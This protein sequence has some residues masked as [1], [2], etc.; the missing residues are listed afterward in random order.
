M[1]G[2]LGVIFGW[3]KPELD[4]EAAAFFRACRPWGFIL[5]GEAFKTKEQ[6][7]RLVA[8]LRAT[9]HDDAMVF[10]DQ[11]GGR[12]ARLKPPQ[13]PAFPAAAQYGK[14]YRKNQTLGLEAARLGFRLMAHE[15]FAIGVRANCAPCLDCPSPNA[16]P[17]IGDRAF[18]EDTA[19]IAALGAQAVIGLREG[20]VAA[21]VK[22]MPGQGRADVDSH[23]AL[24]RVRATRE[25]LARDFAPF[26]ALKSAPMAMTAHVLYEA[27]DDQAPATFSRRLIHD[28]IRGK[29]GFDGL[30][31]S[32]DIGMKALSGSWREKVEALFHAGCDVALHC[33][34]DLSEMDDVARAC[35]RLTGKSLAR[36]HAAST[37]CAQTPAPVDEKVAQ[38]RFAWLM[39]QAALLT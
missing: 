32:D 7:S 10:I 18:A 36:A 33:S 5:F 27:I 16:D 4:D 20:G 14:L 24:P 38:A 29:I 26:K 1:S 12:V 25:D 31:M 19:T 17:A 3:R 11:E 34:G 6:A 22:H 8:Q 35:S 2:P 30:L 37:R 28:V 15:L 23:F 39:K 21:V 9:T 13:W